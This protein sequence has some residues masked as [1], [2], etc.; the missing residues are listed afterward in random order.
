MPRAGLSAGAVVDLALDIIDAQGQEALALS[1]VAARAGVAPP[2]LYKHVGSLA[3]L[4]SLV[5]ARI[6][7]E[8]T[9]LATAA[10]MGLSGDAAIAALMRRLRAYAVEH[11]ARYLAV[12]PDPVHDPALAEPANRFLGVFLAV[13]RSYDLQGPAAIHAI[14]SLRVIVHGFA[15]IESSGGFGLT[16]DPAE[17]YEHLIDMYLATLPRR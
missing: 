14:R 15:A 2:S 17:T 11:P 3:E 16:E 10:V 1:S 7:D 9:D 5:A 8:M 12:P 6:L 4:R 13:L